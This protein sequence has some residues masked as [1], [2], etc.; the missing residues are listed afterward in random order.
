MSDGPRIDPSEVGPYLKRPHGTHKRT[1]TFT[2]AVRGKSNRVE[3]DWDKLCLTHHNNMRRCF[4]F[5][6]TTPLSRPIDSGRSG[7][8][9]ANLVHFRQYEVGDGQRVWYTVDEVNKI[10]TVHRVFLHHPKD[11][12]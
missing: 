11:T 5:L 7:T 10:V 2:Y 8:L 3:S 4:D 6:A 12:E 1:E 9:R